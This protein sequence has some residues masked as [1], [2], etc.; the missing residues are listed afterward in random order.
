M[1]WM[2]W[3]TFYCETD[4]IKYPFACINEDLYKDMG[5]ILGRHYLFFI[6]FPVDHGY[7][8]AGYNRIHVDDCWMASSRDKTGR[9]LANQTRFPSGIKALTKFMHERNLFFG[10]YEDY[11]TKT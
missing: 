6:L 10:I 9:L 7:L 4:C 1:G 3:A 8:D 11:G 2:S 5:N